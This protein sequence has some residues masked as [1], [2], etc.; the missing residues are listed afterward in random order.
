MEGYDCAVRL[1]DEWFGEYVTDIL[2]QVERSAEVESIH[3]TKRIAIGSRPAIRPVGQTWIPPKE[4]AVN[5]KC[6]ADN[7]GWY[8]S[9]S[10][11]QASKLCWRTCLARFA[12]NTSSC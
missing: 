6:V 12:S 11:P 7:T 4:S 5:V 10:W 9:A 3:K 1:L 8:L 2:C